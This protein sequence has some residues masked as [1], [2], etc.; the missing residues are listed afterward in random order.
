MLS[1]VTAATETTLLDVNER[2]RAIGVLDASADA[3]LL[4]MD[5]RASQV[6]AAE[7]NV[8]RAGVAPITVRSEVVSETFRLEEPRQ[9]LITSRRF[10]IA[11][12]SVVEDGET[13]PAGDVEF[14]GTAGIVWRLMDD[15]RTAW[16]ASK[17][18]VNYTAGFQ[19]IPFD[20]KLAA[21]KLISSFYRENARDPNLK[22][23]R[24]EGVSEREYWVGA[25]DDPALPVEVR[26]ILA[27]Y[28][29]RAL[30]FR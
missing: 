3:A 11:I 7:L 16:L 26:E 4:E 30:G 14:D 10:I 18:V 1:L 12:G 19:T 8:A 6:I 5:Q 23:V 29:T 24:V 27:P 17:V 21:A 15:R 9:R 25:K 13:V 22:R 28:R 20:I 2:R